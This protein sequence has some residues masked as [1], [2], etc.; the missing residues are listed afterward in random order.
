MIG[1]F[2]GVA[3][4]VA[5]G[6]WYLTAVFAW[7]ISVPFAY[8]NFIKPRLLP[9]FVAFAEQH[10]PLALLLWPVGWLSL[11]G[12]LAHPRSRPLARAVLGL[13]A[14]AAVALPFMPSLAHLPTDG[15]AIAAGAAALIFPLVSAVTD[16]LRAAPLDEQASGD[17]TGLDAVAVVLAAGLVFGLYSTQAAGRG[18][19]STAGL[20]AS[21]LTHLLTAAALLLGLTAI[22]ALAALRERPVYAEFWLAAIVLVMGL[23]TVMTSL[24]L[25]ALSVTGTARWLGGVAMSATLAMVLVSR[26]RLTGSAQGDGV[27]TALSGVVPVRLS[28]GS[29]WAWAG[30]LLDRRGPRMGRT[31]GE[32]RAGLELPH[33][34]AVGA[35]RVAA[36]N[37]KCI[38]TDQSGDGVGC[39]DSRSRPAACWR[40][41]RCRSAPTSCWF[42]RRRTPA[43]PPRSMRGPSPIPRFG[44][45]AIGCARPP[46]PT[47]A[48]TRSCSATPISAPTSRCGRSTSGTR[49]SPVRRPRTGR[50]SS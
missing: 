26:G 10:G 36:G 16:L 4:V 42:R 32:P 44:R 47:Q 18:P 12:A 3:R 45:C 33:P 40:P 27:L 11:G 6:F 49:H 38:G 25:P 15:R 31:D 21:A 50:T 9:D 14:V 48:S 8:Q 20:G 46:P 28:T 43:R 1:R 30:W 17:R 34:H 13:W 39:A 5:V 7:L 23:T 2:E 19:V 29:P 41:A 35:H 24:V 37:R 22:R